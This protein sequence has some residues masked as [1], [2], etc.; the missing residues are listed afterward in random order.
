MGI[1]RKLKSIVIA[2]L[3]ILILFVI[4]LHSQALSRR[5]NG[6]HR[7]R[8]INRVAAGRHVSRS[9][10]TQPIRALVDASKDG[11]LWWSPQYSSEGF[12]PDK[13]H[14]GKAMA[15]A[16]RARGWEVIELGRGEVITADK[17]EGYDIVIRPEPYSCYSA[18]EAIAY[19]DAVAAGVRLFLM[20]SSAGYD[21][22][23][24]NI[25][26]LR[27]GSRRHISVEKIIPHLLTAGIGLSAIPW[28]TAQE[29]PRES[30]TLAWGPGEDP[31]LGYYALL[32]GYV[33]F[34]GT[35]SF[36]CGSPLL[37]NML[38]FLEST[39]SYEL[40]RQ[41]LDLPVWINAEGPSAPVLISPE[42]GAVLPQPD[43]GPWVFEWIGVPGALKYQIVV[44]G[45]KAAFF[46]VD[47]QTTSTS[48]VIPERSSYIVD[49]NAIGWRWSVR[50]Q[51]PDGQWGN[52]SEERLFDIADRPQQGGLP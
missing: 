24:A 21:D 46:L 28:V 48:F 35:S 14:Q 43:A 47:D 38:E 6:I 34:A 49:C 50:T 44:L 7:N 45:S 18:S 5:P 33:L 40:Q 13:A 25:F 15:D 39:S 17:L 2:G 23:V 11:G 16:M 31:I 42:P 52:W 8:A 10:A 22:R 32:E 37:G 20:G 29:M 1:S 36:I 27:F 3:A 26:G 51:G 4:E 41:S 19:R 9:R 30:V 12:D